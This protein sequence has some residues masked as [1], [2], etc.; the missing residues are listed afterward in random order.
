MKSGDRVRLS[1]DAEY[2]FKNNET[3]PEPGAEGV[4]TGSF[5]GMG[6]DWAVRWDD[7][8]YP[9]NCYPESDLEEIS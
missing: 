7:E 2:Q 3:N 1:E 8:D 4:I 9:L 5:S 6:F